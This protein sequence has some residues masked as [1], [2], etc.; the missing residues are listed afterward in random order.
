MGHG[1]LAREPD[2]IIGL[3]GKPDGDTITLL[4]VLRHAAPPPRFQIKRGDDLWWKRTG[5]LLIPPKLVPCLKLLIKRGRSYAGWRDSIAKAE[6]VSVKTALRRI[7]EAT[8]QGFVSPNGDKLQDSYFKLT[9]EARRAL[10]RA[11]ASV[12]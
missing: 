12:R 1:L 2:A 11:K 6:E 8:E 9:S 3:D 10:R 7:K 4:F 5:K